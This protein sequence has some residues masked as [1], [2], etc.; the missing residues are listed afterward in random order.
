MARVRA[1]RPPRRSVLAWLRTPRLSPLGALGGAA[2][3]AVAAAVLAVRLAGGPAPGAAP[4]GLAPVVAQ[5]TLD[6]PDARTVAVAGDFNGWRPE[7]TP[8][9]RGEG[10]TWSVR[11]PL[12]PGRRYQYQFVVDGRWVTDPSA[13]AAADDG[14]GGRNAV[15]DL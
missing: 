15:L 8:L 1:R 5:L 6:A 7:A 3:A 14:F 11:L 9:R 2:A 13:P 10:G 12:E 4:E